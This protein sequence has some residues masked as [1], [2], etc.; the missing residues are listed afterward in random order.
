M[1]VFKLH[2]RVF[3]L[4]SSANCLATTVNKMS[5]MLVYFEGDSK[6][7]D[8]RKIEEYQTQLFRIDTELNRLLVQL[9]EQVDEAR[10][11]AREFDLKNGDVFYPADNIEG[12]S[13]GQAS[14]Q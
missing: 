8:L 6:D 12:V 13:S 10:E 1:D 11:K 7:E 5:T 4:Q 2:Q 14:G 3:H 9:I